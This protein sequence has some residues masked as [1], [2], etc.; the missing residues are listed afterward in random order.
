MIQFRIPYQATSPPWAAQRCQPSAGNLFHSQFGPI[1][2]CQGART[3]TLDLSE[4]GLIDIWPLAHLFNT[5]GR[6]CRASSSATKPA[7]LQFDRIFVCVRTVVTRAGPTLVVAMIVLF[8]EIE[9][10]LPLYPPPI[11]ST[12]APRNLPARRSSSATFASSNE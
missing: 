11:F 12:A 4:L 8:S 5:V 6:P 2:S 3:S 1:W 7:N 10:T 9:L